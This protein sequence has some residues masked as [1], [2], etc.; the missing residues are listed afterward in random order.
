MTIQATVCGNLGQDGEM[1]SLANG[2]SVLNFSVGASSGYGQNK[3]TE[4]VRCAMFGKRAETLAQYMNKGTKVTVF[5]SLATREWQGS[6]GKLNT[7]VELNVNDVVL[8]G[9]GQPS[10][11]SQASQHAPAATPAPVDTSIDPSDIPF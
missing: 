4:W 8:Q 3:K 7:S 2:N 11:Q 10:P 5:G 1:K 6:D 9:S